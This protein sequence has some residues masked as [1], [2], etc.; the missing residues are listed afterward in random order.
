MRNYVAAMD[1][2]SE[3]L[4]NNC[5]SELKAEGK[6]FNIFPF[7]LKAAA[8]TIGEITTGVDFKMLEE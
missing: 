6:S 2:T 1:R 7:M 3:K 5:F 4:V 8:Q